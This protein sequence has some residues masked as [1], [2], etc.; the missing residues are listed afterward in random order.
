MVLTALALV[1][2]GTPKKKRGESTTL[3]VDETI[4]D[5]AQI[6]STPVIRLEGV[7]LVVGLDHT[8]VDPPPSFYRQKLLDEMRKAG[9]E[10]ANKLLADPR[11]T[12]VIARVRLPTGVST[13]DRIDVELEL[14]PASGTTSLAGGYLLTTRL[15]EVMIAG[16]APREGQVLAKAQGPVMIGTEAKPTDRRVGRVLGGARPLKDIPFNLVLKQERK[17]IRTVALVEGVVNQRFHQSEG[18]DQKGMA[19]GKSNQI[20]V[21][22]VPQV[23]HQNQDR[24]FRVIKLLQIIDTPEKRAERMAR[25]GQNLLDPKTAGVAALR[26]EG[27]GPNAIDTLKGGL[28]SPN[29]QVQ[30]FAAEALAYLGDT[31]GVDVLGE[32]VAH[33]PDFRAYALAALAAIDEEAA[34]LKLRKLLSEPDVEVRYGAFNALRVLDERDPFLG[35]VRVL[36]EP[37]EPDDG[38]A[39]ALALAGTGQRSRPRAEDPFELYVVDCEGPPLVHIA[40]TRRCEIVLFG[41]DQKLLT[42]VVLGQGE[43]LLNAADGDDQIQISR[44]VPARLDAADPKVVASLELGDVIRRAANLGANYPE[45]VTILQSAARQKNLPG[46][47]IVDAVPATSPVY[48]QAQIN[49]KDT[50]AKKDDAVKQAKATDA[51]KSG[52]FNW[53]RRLSRP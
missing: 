2:A 13:R 11:V 16:G 50:T 33:R 43:I 18:V 30:F 51:P 25:W 53:F 20:L 37:P 29:A 49:G 19:T 48:T 22:K 34:H 47:L 42:P 26:L 12:L 8:G 17:S 38:D 4:A 40:R 9:V 45:L 44:I 36:D 5:L 21:L 23:Y 15:A 41:R 52:L 10:N 46:P 31:A 27:L 35:R 7:G 3:K 1:G 39:M 24:Y 6:V 32:T 14:P 28:A